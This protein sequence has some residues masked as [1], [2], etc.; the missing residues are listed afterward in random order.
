MQ[1]GMMSQGGGLRHAK[2]HIRA[3]FFSPFPGRR[4]ITGAV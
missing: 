4:M 2:T 1:T 3:P